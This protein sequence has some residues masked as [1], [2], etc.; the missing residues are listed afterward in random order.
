MK[1][2][3]LIAALVI[4]LA[5]CEKEK[6]ECPGAIEQT[7]AF[8]DFTRI[9]TGETFGLTISKGNDFSVKA[10]GCADDLADL[11]ITITTAGLLDI[12]YK[13]YKKNRYRVDLTITLPS[14]LSLDLSGGAKATI[15]GFAGQHNVIRN[16][17]SG[18]AECTVSGT[19][20]N[21]QIDLSGTSI[22]HLT[23]DTESLYGNLS[24]NSKLNS[25]TTTATEVDISV[26]GTAK[27]YVQPVERFFAEASGE[28]RV[29]YRGNPPVTN[30]VT[31]GNGRIIHE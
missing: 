26:S 4:S 9:R 30:L 5:S 13:N 1:K 17:L 25:Y 29:Y 24:G 31:S 3:L 2:Y 11:D 16:V 8:T 15:S 27:A 10:R 12:K 7:L 28:S 19:A 21:A 23:G 18:D 20:I 22:L 14:L 6:K